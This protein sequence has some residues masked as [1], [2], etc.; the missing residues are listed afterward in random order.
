[1]GQFKGGDPALNIKRKFSGLKSDLQ[2]KRLG[3]N[4]NGGLFQ[5]ASFWG[6]QDTPSRLLALF[7][8][9]AVVFLAA[10]ILWGKGSSAASGLPSG[11]GEDSLALAEKPRYNWQVCENLG[12]GPVPGL[13]EPRQRLRLC[14][15]QGWQVLVYCLN[16][17]LPVAEIGTNCT[18][19]GE[20]VYWCGNGMQPVKEYRVVQEPDDTPTPTAS[21]TPTPTPTDTPTA[22]P[23]AT[24]T[25]Q[26]P[27]FHGYLNPDSH[28]YEYAHPHCNFNQDTGIARSHP[29]PARR[30]GLPFISRISGRYSRSFRG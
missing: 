8:T 25:P 3:F 24:F 26:H 5:R 29:H 23:T 9:I 2:K 1:V 4:R 18:R 10:V 13:T 7:V 14:H 22:T 17:E 19:V 11:Y 16:P 30:Q 20:D 21:S 15:N 12:V 27:D 6:K 28:I